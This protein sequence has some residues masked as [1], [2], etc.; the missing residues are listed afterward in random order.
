MRGWEARKV[1]EDLESEDDAEEGA[2][3]RT[4]SQIV[5]VC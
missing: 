4:V 2:R 5:N 1:D 3:E